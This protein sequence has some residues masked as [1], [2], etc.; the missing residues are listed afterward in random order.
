MKIRYFIFFTQSN[1]KML[2]SKKISLETEKKRKCDFFSRKD[3]CKKC[4]KSKKNGKTK[5]KRV[6]PLSSL[7]ATV[8]EI[9]IS[10]NASWWA[11]FLILEIERRKFLTLKKEEHLCVINL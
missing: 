8:P 1:T 2:V 6:V 5:E 7:Y 4:K 9:Q 10:K 3:K 11:I